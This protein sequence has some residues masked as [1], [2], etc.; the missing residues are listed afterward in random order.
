[1]GLAIHQE[2][3]AAAD[4][5]AAVVVKAHRSFARVDQLLI[6]LIQGLEQGDV[7]RQLAQLMALVTA[8]LVGGGLPP[9]AQ[10]EF[11]R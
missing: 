1:M 8:G 9:D 10:G 11:H 4:A 7:R 3:A 6:Q 5:L 2:A